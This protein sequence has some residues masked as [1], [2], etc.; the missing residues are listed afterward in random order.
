[1]PHPWERL[2]D[3][4][5]Q[6]YAAFETF[7]D[8]KP[9]A[10]GVVAAYN[11]YQQNK[12]RPPAN[13]AS[14]TWN[15]WAKKFI[16][17]ERARQYDE[18]TNRVELEAREKVIA[19]DATAKAREELRAKRRQEHEDDEWEARCMVLA[20]A[21]EMLRT[22]LFRTKSVS[23]DGKTV[24]IA[25]AKWTLSTTARM[26]ELASQLGRASA[27]LPQRVEDDRP[28]DN[29]KELFFE[30][31]GLLEG[32]MPDG[33]SPPMPEDVL[34]TPPISI[35]ATKVAGPGANLKQPTLTRP[36]R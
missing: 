3:E 33:V 29:F 23:P 12:S 8:L 36:G 17:V 9:E 30:S 14:G 34:A 25:P 35:N 27:R 1:M 18:R 15:A 26:L 24:E 13:Q 11:V 21:K 28:A 19:A 32:A 2:P 31:D 22:K 20:M 4:S 6:A 10:R 5:P 7:R 16:W